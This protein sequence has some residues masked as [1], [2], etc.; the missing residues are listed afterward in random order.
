MGHVIEVFGLSRRYGDT[1]A[2][3]EI[4]FS[5]EQG[6]IFGL[7][8][9][10]GAGK[11]TL[12]SILT[13]TVLPSAGTASI[14]GISILEN[15]A[16]VKKRIGLVPQD[17]A[18]YQSLTAYEN[19]LFFGYLSGRAIGD[20]KRQIDVLLE[21]VGLSEW[22]NCITRVFSGGMKRRLNL[23][24]GLVHR[25]MVLFLDEPTVGVDPQSRNHILQCI[26]RLAQ[27]GMTVFYTTH[28]M[29]E[30]EAICDR[31]AIIDRGAILALDTPADLIR[32]F[33]SGTIEIGVDMLS[34]DALRRLQ[35]VPEISDYRWCD[36]SLLVKTVNDMAPIIPRLIT[37]IQEDE[38]SVR[39]LKTKAPSLEAVFLSLTGRSLRDEVE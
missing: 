13:C 7:L 27:E 1:E 5:V 6:E 17:I 33:G 8:G 16:E 37:L 20:M 26:R 28:Y 4:T 35:Q 9:P 11:T 14:D 18:I 23:A 34:A 15:P 2:L 24:I 38:K 36:G 3:K 31:V 10:N 25:P 32:K 29:E 39:F 30:A 19:L 22:R 21:M 12:I